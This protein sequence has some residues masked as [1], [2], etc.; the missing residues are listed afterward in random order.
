[1][2]LFYKK[3]LKPS[4]LD[5]KQTRP[6][7]FKDREGTFFENYAAARDQMFSSGRSD[8]MANMLYDAYKPI[9]NH[10][11]K[12]LKENNIVTQNFNLGK[13]E[14]TYAGLR[15]EIMHN[16][17]YLMSKSASP[18]S[19]YLGKDDFYFK[20]ANALI[21]TIKE[22]PDLFPELEDITLQSIE[23]QAIEIALKDHA[24]LQGITENSPGFF[25]ALAR[26]AGG[27]RGAATDPP[28]AI[29]MLMNLDPKMGIGKLMLR[30]ALV[31]GVSEAAVQE[32][33]QKWY[34]ELGLDYSFEDF[35]KAVATGSALGF[36]LPG[37]FK[38]GGQT[39]KL[40]N[41]WVQKGLEVLG[42]NKRKLSPLGEEA[43]AMEQSI[44]DLANSNPNKNPDNM[45]NIA[46]HENAVETAK[47]QLLNN[48]SV[49]VD[50]I[51]P[52]DLSDLELN[53]KI[54][55]NNEHSVHSFDPN[56]IEVDAKAFQFKEGG[57]AFGVTDKL[58]N[59]KKWDTIAAGTVT[60]FERAD[61]KKF[62]AD[63]HQRLGLAK[64]IMSED[65]S[66]NIKMN[67]FVLR[68][69]DG[70]SA[71]FAMVSAAIT[72][73]IRGTGSDLDAAKIYRSNQGLIQKEF[74]DII[75]PSSAMF[76]RAED[77]SKLSDDN[78]GMIVNQVIS[79]D[80]GAI[81]GRIIP[82]DP[83]IQKA[84]ISVLSRQK[85]DNQFQAEAIVRQVKATETDTSV[86]TS[87]F[88]DEV[89]VESLFVER[90]KILD[91]AK[92]II[93]RDRA[94]FST[95]VRNSTEFEKGGNQLNKLG[96]QQKV[97]DDGSM[98][99]IL[100]ASADKKGAISD[101]LTK[102]AREAK[103]TNRYGQ[104]AKGYVEALRRGIE[105]G[106]F[107]STDFSNN[108]R[109]IDATTEVSN[110][111]P[112]TKQNENIAKFDDP[113]GAAAKEQA[114]QLQEE[115][116]PERISE[117]FQADVRLRQDL[118]KRIDEGALEAEVDSHPAVTKAIEEANAL[119]ETT[120]LKGYG[121][122]EFNESREFTFGTEKV[123]G[124]ENAIDKLYEGAK[125]LAWGG[126]TKGVV[127]QQKKAVIVL[128]AP[129]AGKSSIADPIARKINAAVI[130]PDEAK[131][132]LP[133]YK[134]GIGANAVHEE[135][136]K[137]ADGVL[138]LAVGM[139]DNIV[140]PKVGGKADSI[141]KLAKRLKAEGYDITLMDMQV[142]YKE[143]RNRMFKR[144][145]KTGRLINPDYVR[146][147]GSNPTKTYYTLKQEGIADGYT[148]IDNNGGFD[149]PKPVLEDTRNILENTDIRLRQKG[150]DG[151]S[152]SPIS[153]NERNDSQIVEEEIAELDE[154]LEIP[155]NVVDNNGNENFIPQS[156]KSLKEE[157]AADKNVVD[158][159]EYCTI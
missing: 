36:I 38:I 108:G 77:L 86:Q 98:L 30:E 87:L 139:G 1:M 102:S 22:N 24:E 132:V 109:S 158:R 58:K 69:A 47:N 67:A 126:T 136:S 51:D 107:N 4:T 138:Q 62:I 42:V 144:F 103:E 44:K 111:S 26:F 99:A 7:Q 57:D 90:A 127:L 155:F 104:A 25:N 149:Q 29:S 46:K 118:N 8:S 85:V 65:P 28:I 114:D 120:T 101:A 84:A 148:Q 35:T 54:N 48:E 89:E 2:D 55:Q 73:I 34:G 83:A 135:S 5:Y 94:A 124:Y 91:E 19:G 14:H 146:Q 131:K 13:N 72:N 12:T 61:G 20:K 33:V 27:M 41:D 31:G 11:N 128:G 81:V 66:Q 145:V 115:I 93:K 112:N 140:I 23:Q 116:M 110:V 43:K 79:S 129:A 156:I 37:A 119:P 113:G 82:D 92:R 16:P 76:R 74:A 80:F 70:I 97:L 153:R 53:K 49:E 151:D 150:G 154:N 75:P 141:R 68:E 18:I 15:N 40:T 143:A 56:E 96:N 9:L 59:T 10:V 64:R 117:A 17:A 142:S 45:E 52:A 137:L 88:G 21:N 157:F 122:K 123:I 125:D 121:T 6:F 78:W 106:D 3:S 71:E 147:V 134:G 50:P 152:V 63:G 159:L 60:V 130:D 95:L 100:M 39:V 32:R 133:E 105:K